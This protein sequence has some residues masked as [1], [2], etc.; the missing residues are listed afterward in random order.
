MEDSVKEGQE[1][2]EPCYA[3]HLASPKS[4]LFLL[5]RNRH[6]PWEALGHDQLGRV[7][8]TDECAILSVT[9]INDLRQSGPYLF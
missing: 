3:L 6:F 1:T 2:R 5:L 9:Q 7:K 8:R 4:V